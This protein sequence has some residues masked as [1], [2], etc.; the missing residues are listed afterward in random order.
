MATAVLGTLATV[1]G[2]LAGDGIGAVLLRFALPGFNPTGIPG[3][4]L[5]IGKLLASV[6][7]KNPTES[8]KA[9]LLKWCD[10]HDPANKANLKPE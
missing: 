6:H 4:V 1:V 2:F 9:Q 8:S 10:E 5:K 3:K 7:R